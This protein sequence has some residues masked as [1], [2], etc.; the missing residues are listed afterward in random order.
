MKKCKAFN[1][2]CE[3]VNVVNPNIILDQ[4]D[5]LPNEKKIKAVC[6]LHDETFF[7]YRSVTYIIYNCPKCKKPYTKD[8]IKELNDKIDEIDENFRKEC[9]KEEEK[10]FEIKRKELTDKKHDI[11]IN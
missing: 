8:E 5:W 1:K 7:M 6:K 4:K 11:I 3:R 9:I 2:F 10:R